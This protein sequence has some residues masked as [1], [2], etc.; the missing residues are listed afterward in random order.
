MARRIGSEVLQHWT[1]GVEQ[2]GSDG[3]LEMVNEYRGCW[4]EFKSSDE[5]AGSAGVDTV[6][7]GLWIPARL[8]VS[9]RDDFFIWA[10]DPET[11]YRTAGKVGLYYNRRGQLRASYIP[12]EVRS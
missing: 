7:M 10:K 3:E 9:E 11:K 6:I 8:T 4:V 2:F 5:N 12:V 1:K